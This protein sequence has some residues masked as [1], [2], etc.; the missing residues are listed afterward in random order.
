ME[1]GDAS[2]GTH[3]NAWQCVVRWDQTH[4]I[5]SV[6]K[7]KT[8]SWTAARSGFLAVCIWPA[9]NQAEV[10]LKLFSHFWG[11]A[12][13]GY[14]MP[15]LEVIPVCLHERLPMF[16]TY[17]IERHLAHSLFPSLKRGLKWAPT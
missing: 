4:F 1:C 8:H 5:E 2:D 13:F 9:G 11:Q 10:I 6:C 7:D 16:F 15:C 12:E 14:V 3:R 17:N